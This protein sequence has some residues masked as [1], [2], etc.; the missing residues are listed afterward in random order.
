MKGRFLKVRALW[1]GLAI[2]SAACGATLWAV[3]ALAVQAAPDPAAAFLATNR[4]A[5]G[6]VETA[7][8]LQYKVLT[9]GQGDAKPTDQDV[10]LINYEGRLV[11]GTSFDKSA[12]PTPM[13]IAGVVPG[14]AEG[15]KLM[16]RGAKLRFWIKPALGY[17]S[18]AS[19]P[20]PANSVLVFDVEML[21]FM[22]AADF[23]QMMEQQQSQAPAGTAPPQP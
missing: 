7:S 10:A 14:F 3:P 16:P 19:G 4:G 2:V 23:R 9:P 1:A 12:A 13:P 8:G 15:L 21:D 11:D 18:E 17:G 6:V 22:P 20:I 5:I